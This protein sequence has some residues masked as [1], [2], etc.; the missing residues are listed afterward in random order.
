MAPRFVETYAAMHPSPMTSGL[1]WMEDARGELA[2]LS[3]RRNLTFWMEYLE[4]QWVEA[5]NWSYSN[6]SVAAVSFEGAP[7]PPSLTVQLLVV[8]ILLGVL[9]C[10]AVGC[11][12][13]HI[14]NRYA[15]SKKI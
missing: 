6:F 11:H 15:Q 12:R 7:A 3:S 5:R 4:N 13:R 8:G 10:L 9:Q 1:Q 2:F 14:L